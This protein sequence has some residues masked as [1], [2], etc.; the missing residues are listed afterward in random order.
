M[1]KVSICVA[2]AAI[3][4]GC[5]VVNVRPEHKEKIKKYRQEGKLKQ[6]E[7]EIGKTVGMGATVCWGFIPGANH[8]H[9]ARKIKQSP[10][11]AQFDQD[12]H[13]LSSSLFSIGTV[14]S[15]FSVIPYV[16]N[17]TMPLQVGCSPVDVI[18][19]NNLAYMYHIQSK[20]SSKE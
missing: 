18:R 15:I 19:I 17:F 10:Y 2:I 5:E 12:Y 6:A 11:A 20:E 7:A 3:A 1:K 9:M 4:S 16:Y 13:S 8:I 14:C